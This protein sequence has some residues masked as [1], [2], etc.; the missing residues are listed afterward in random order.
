MHPGAGKTYPMRKST[1]PENPKKDP[2][3]NPVSVSNPGI[4]SIFMRI[5]KEKKNR[6]TEMGS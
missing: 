1:R 5:L 4:L 3:A 2:L 6:F